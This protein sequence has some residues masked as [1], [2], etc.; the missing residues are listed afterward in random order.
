M[1]NN[2][3]ATK[4]CRK[5]KVE[6]PFKAF[7]YGSKRCYKCEYDHKKTYF[8]EY[9][10]K[11]REQVLAQQREAYRRDTENKPKRKRGRPSKHQPIIEIRHEEGTLNETVMD[12]DIA[13]SPEEDPLRLSEQEIERVKELKQT[14]ETWIEKLNKVC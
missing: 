1:E 10:E 4:E 13:L 9:Y 14:L 8:N 7:R 6:L 2:Q 11:K 12:I 5:C 3:A